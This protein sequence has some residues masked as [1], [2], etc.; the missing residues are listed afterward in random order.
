MYAVG[1][2][3]SPAV[4]AAAAS[5]VPITVALDPAFRI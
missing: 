5:V 3:Q 1:D 4:V 2:V